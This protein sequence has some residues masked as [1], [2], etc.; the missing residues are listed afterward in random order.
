MHGLRKY[1][2]RPAGRGRPTL[3]QSASTKCPSLPGW[4]VQRQGETLLQGRGNRLEESNPSA[5]IN[6][7]RPEIPNFL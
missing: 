3:K 7:S 6:S 2:E 1:A 4:A 5:W